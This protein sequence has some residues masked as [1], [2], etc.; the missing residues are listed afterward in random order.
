MII[1]KPMEDLNVIKI[2]FT[3]I[4]TNLL[5]YNLFKP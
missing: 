3:H 1:M 5:E 2:Q 4:L